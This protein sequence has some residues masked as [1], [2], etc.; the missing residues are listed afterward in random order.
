[1]WQSGAG[2]EH[3]NTI[4]RFPFGFRYLPP[5]LHVWFAACDRRLSNAN[6]KNQKNDMRQAKSGSVL[7]CLTHPVPG[8]AE[9]GEHPDEARLQQTHQ[10]EALLLQQQVTDGHRRAQVRADTA[11]C[12]GHWGLAPGGK[13]A[14]LHK[15]L[16]AQKQYG[17]A[18]AGGGRKR[19]T[20]EAAAVHGRGRQK[21]S[22]QVDETGTRRKKVRATK[23]T[24]ARSP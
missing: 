2:T 24:C 19:T 11:V 3:C 23:P 22:L 6:N 15:V 12:S 8:G 17:H 13:P 9:Q 7:V 10:H 16:P 18:Q 5:L 14:A 20:A 4:L 1:M 21:K